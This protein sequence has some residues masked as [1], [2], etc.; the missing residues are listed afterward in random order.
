MRPA[1]GPR[2]PGGG[3]T[4]AAGPDKGRCRHRRCD[5]SRKR[6]PPRTSLIR[7]GRDGDLT[8]M[9]PGV[10]TRREVH[11]RDHRMRFNG[12]NRLTLR[13]CARARARGIKTSRRP[14]SEW[15][16]SREDPRCP[17]SVGELMR[18]EKIPGGDKSTCAASAIKGRRNRAA[19]ILL[20]LVFLP[21]SSRLRLFSSLPAFD[22]ASPRFI[23]FSSSSGI[24]PDL[25]GDLCR[26]TETR[27]RP[28]EGR[29]T[30]RAGEINNRVSHV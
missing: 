5:S 9:R 6:T 30:S 1:S 20:F 28:H 17:A 27:V 19:A 7:R 29:G 4:P 16:R 13:S 26:D 2:D 15:T 22:R 24:F 14:E 8:K 25:H 11:R 21:P 18:P 3:R 12:A 23:F 10:V